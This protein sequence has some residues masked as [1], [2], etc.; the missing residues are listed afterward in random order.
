MSDA[1]DFAG[2]KMDLEEVR[3]VTAWMTQPEWRI[4]TRMIASRR[5]GAQRRAFS[6]KPPLVDLGGKDKAKA[7][8]PHGYHNDKRQQAAGGVMAFEAV[9]G[10]REAAK[11]ELESIENQ[12]AN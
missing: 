5:D 4:F 8:L 3:A 12:G 11:R 7:V 2:M 10:M 1:V 6:T 9:I